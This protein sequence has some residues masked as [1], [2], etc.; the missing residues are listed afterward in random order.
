[1]EEINRR[2][3]VHVSVVTN[4]G[5]VHVELD[6]SE[7]RFLIFAFV[8][9]RVRANHSDVRRSLQRGPKKAVKNKSLNI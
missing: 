4:C 1:M 6:L 5:A 3:Q 2:D 8:L 9:R 7:R